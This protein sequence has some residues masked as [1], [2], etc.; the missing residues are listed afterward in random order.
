M[1]SLS[2]C[3][4]PALTPWHEGGLDEFPALPGQAVICSSTTKQ[5]MH[6]APAR[7]TGLTA[8]AS[9]PEANPQK[10]GKPLGFL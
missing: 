9:D 2:A 8:L 5:V 6:S 3:A 10:P 1:Y 4:G 7:G